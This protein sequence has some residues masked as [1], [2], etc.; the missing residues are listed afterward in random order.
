MLDK[1]P[2]EEKILVRFNNKTIDRI[3]YITNLFKKKYKVSF[4]LY[5]L[6]YSRIALRNEYFYFIYKYKD[7]I[8]DIHKKLFPEPTEPTN[9]KSYYTKDGILV[10]EKPKIIMIKELEEKYEKEKN[11][12]KLYYL[13]ENYDNIPDEILDND[14]WWNNLFNE[15]AI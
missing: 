14:E 12:S 10:L 4:E 7:S 15:I 1:L 11:N 6:E 5:D 3:F 2:I 13:I 9:L 8:A